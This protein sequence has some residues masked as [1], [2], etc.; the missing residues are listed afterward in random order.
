MQIKFHKLARITLAMRTEFQCNTLP[1]PV[2]WIGNT[3]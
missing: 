3:G 1:T 2:F